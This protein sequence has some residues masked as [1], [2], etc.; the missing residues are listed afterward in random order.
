M[1]WKENYSG[2]SK[3]LHPCK[4]SINIGLSMNVD[5]VIDVM[6]ILPRNINHAFGNNF[7]WEKHQT[8]IGSHDAPSD[9]HVYI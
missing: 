3:G 8:L 4:K 5:D 2:I 6:D 9:S 7:P 1:D